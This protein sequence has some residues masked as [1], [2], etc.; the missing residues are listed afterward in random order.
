MKANIVFFVTSLALLNTLT[1]F[2]QELDDSMFDM[3]LEDLMNIEITSVSKK[4]ERLQD[5]SSSIYVVTSK[6]IEH[7]GATTLH[8]VLRLVPGYWGVQ[9]E[10]SNAESNVRY[11]QVSNGITGTVLYLLDGTPI[12][13]LMASSFSF[14]NF[15]IP[16]DEIDRIEFIRGSGGT[17]YGANSATGVVNIFT[18]TPDNYDG[19]NARAEAGSAGY[20][21]TSVRA[22]G[23]VSDNFSISG[24]GKMRLFKGWDSL[25][26]TDENG[27]PA[28]ANSRFTE[29]FDKIDMYSFGLKAK[30]KLSEQGALSFNSHYNTLS[31]TDYTGY[32]ASDFAFSGNDVLVQKDVSANRFVGNLRYD[33]TFNENHSIFVR[34][35][36]NMENDFNRLAGG[37]EVSNST[38]DF[39]VQDNISLG[40]QND[41]SVGFNYRINKIDVHDITSTDAVNYTD[42]QSTESLKGAFVQD[43]VKLMDGKLNFLLGI[44]AENYSLVND[45]YYLSPMA[46]VSY[47]PTDNFTLW[48]GFTQSFSTPGFNNTNID[49]YL[50]QTPSDAAWTQAAT[51][52]V[53]QGAYD[54]A[55]AGGAD[56]ATAQ[57]Q[58]NA[59]IS[60][61]AGMAVIDATAQALMAANPNIA[62]KNGTHTVPTRFRTWEIGFRANIDNQLT[63]ESNFYHTTIKD[64]IGISPDA[65]AQVNEESPTQPGRFATYYLYG[66]YVQGETYGTESTVKIIPV[67]GITFELTH[68]YLNTSWELQE[69]E[70]FDIN[71]PNIVAEK[72]RTPEVSRVPAHVFRFKGDFDLPKQINL[73]VSMIYGTKFNSQANYVVDQERFENIAIPDPNAVVVAPDND[74]TIINLRLEKKWLDDQLTTYIFGNDIFNEG[75]EA[76]TRPVFNVTRSQIGAMFGFGLNYKL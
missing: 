40:E 71:D 65:A 39:E 20:V 15:D 59:Y 35:S 19:I 51:Q 7:S 37:F 42:P 11:S 46:K 43:K 17:I 32:Y 61:S 9:D 41:L 58:A 24:Y 63:F 5:V 69:N 33:H 10:Y 36:S 4:A 22:G 76:N 56:D 12:Q 3:S 64:G 8:E 57:S 45:D 52:G 29:D 75:I 16:L 14:R 73:S 26:G 6:D 27:D 34:A 66:N 55:I 72:D 70:D 18:K 28:V 23:M 60:S 68:S 54:A 31:T 38:L 21:A 62:A 44:K 48:G 67:H 74:R 2:G 13:D 50:F 47:I 25:A 49:L 30:Y 1:V 53:Y